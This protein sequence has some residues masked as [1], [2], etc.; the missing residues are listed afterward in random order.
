MV[1]NEDEV[2]WKEWKDRKE[3]RNKGR[4]GVGQHLFLFVDKIIS[5]NL[6]EI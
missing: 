5:F 3:R 1:K 6:F 2:K 4:L